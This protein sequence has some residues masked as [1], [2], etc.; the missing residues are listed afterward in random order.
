M[1]TNCLTRPLKS[2]AVFLPGFPVSAEEI[3]ALRL[4]GTPPAKTLKLRYSY[5]LFQADRR[6]C[7]LQGGQNTMCIV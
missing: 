5:G 7:V 2:K 1:G 6:E 3:F 4:D